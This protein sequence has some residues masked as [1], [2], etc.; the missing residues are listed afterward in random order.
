[1]WKT[2]ATQRKIYSIYKHDVFI[3]LMLHLFAC[4]YMFCVIHLLRL[5]VFISMDMFSI[6]VLGFC[7]SAGHNYMDYLTDCS[8]VLGRTPVHSLKE[9]EFP[10][11]LCT[12][13]LMAFGHLLISRC[14]KTHFFNALGSMWPCAFIWSFLDFD[15]ICPNPLFPQPCLPLIACWPGCLFLFFV[16]S[17][18][19]QE[20][21]T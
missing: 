3:I 17:Q 1:M 2:I 5:G 10:Q 11:R 15:D 20:T 19:V 8:G 4:R 13:R 7:F 18:W 21:Q 12:Y 14:S 16:S 9:F 6:N